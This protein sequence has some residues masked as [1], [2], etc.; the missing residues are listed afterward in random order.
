VPAGIR[1]ELN[2]TASVMCSAFDEGTRT[3]RNNVRVR[4]KPVG[5]PE[6]RP[7]RSGTTNNKGELFLGR[8]LPG[9]YEFEALH[10]DY[11]PGP[12]VVATV[13]A[14]DENVPVDLP[15]DP[16][17]TIDGVVRNAAGQA[18]QNCQ[19]W[20]RGTEDGKRVRNRSTRTAADGT[21]RLT[22]LRGGTYA[23]SAMHGAYRP[24][25]QQSLRGGERGL[26]VD[27]GTPVRRRR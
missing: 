26:V 25:S 8:L 20:V 9:A 21:F 15:L 23:L 13:K 2:P 24:F 10:N 14:G 19:I 7:A 16:G 22:G 4:I 1:L 11:V 5:E 18:I 6:G 3:V 27:L 12:P 17:L